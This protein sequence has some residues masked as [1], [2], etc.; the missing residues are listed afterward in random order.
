M[1]VGSRTYRVEDEIVLNIRLCKPLAISGPPV[2]ARP[3]EL[4]W[5]CVF[6]LVRASFAPVLSPSRLKGHGLPT[7]RSV[8]LVVLPE[9]L[10][11]ARGV[12]TKC[13]MG[14]HVS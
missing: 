14:R 9:A 6:L 7:T 13:S 8:R 2:E 4:A 11:W 3:L 1:S 12:T 5:R 10:F